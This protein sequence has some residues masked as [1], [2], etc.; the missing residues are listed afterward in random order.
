MMIMMHQ[1]G[2]RVFN[3]EPVREQAHYTAEAVGSVAQA[4]MLYR[5]N[6]LALVAGGR[7]PKYADNTV[8]IYDDR[9]AKMVLEFTLPDQV[10]AVRLKRDKVVIKLTQNWG[11]FASF[12]H[13]VVCVCRNKIHVFS[14]PHAPRKLFSL[15]TRDNPLG[16]CELSPLRTGDR[17]VMVFPGYKALPS[18]ID[19]YRSPYHSQYH[20]ERGF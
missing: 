17:E 1:D 5:T 9:A 10:L 20:D 19:E 12:S 18:N 7:K 11:K 6:L 16:L 15:D 2:L 8:M 4:E 13:Q 3:V 14:F